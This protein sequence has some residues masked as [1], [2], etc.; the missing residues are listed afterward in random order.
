MNSRLSTSAK[1]SEA[2]RAPPNH[3]HAPVRTAA[4]PRAVAMARTMEMNAS[5]VPRSTTSSDPFCN[6]LRNPP[7]ATPSSPPNAITAPKP[8]TIRSPNPGFPRPI[9]T[10]PKLAVIVTEYPNA[11]ALPPSDSPTPQMSRSRM[12][13]DCLP[14]SVAGSRSWL[15]VRRFDVPPRTPLRRAIDR[16]TA[17]PPCERRPRRGGGLRRHRYRAWIRSSAPDTHTRQPGHLGRDRSSRV[18]VAPAGWARWR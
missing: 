15:M 17:S 14:V 12:P 13:R 11:V 1:T 3:A 9:S 18:A 6:G 10:A 7:L 4:T 16:T 8:N 5:D 2:Q